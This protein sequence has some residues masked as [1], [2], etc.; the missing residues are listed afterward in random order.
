M[1]FIFT[2]FPILDVWQGSEF[3]SE[4][5]KCKKALGLFEKMALN[6]QLVFTLPKSGRE[7]LDQV[8][9]YV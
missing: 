5:N 1:D 3:A 9:K 8:M 4:F 7:T 6:T 2:K